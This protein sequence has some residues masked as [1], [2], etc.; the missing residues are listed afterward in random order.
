MKT[1]TGDTHEC[2]CPKCGAAIQDLWDYCTLDA[3]DEVKCEACEAWVWVLSIE[4]AHAVT[5]GVEEVPA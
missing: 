3:G 4:T 2:A 1:T 5:L